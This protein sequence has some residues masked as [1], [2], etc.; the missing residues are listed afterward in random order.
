M[1]TEKEIVSYLYEFGNTKESDII[2]YG[3]K[4]FNYSSEK[5]KKVI[6]RMAIKGKIHYV[7][8]SKLEP[9]EVYI[10][11]KEPLPPEI[12]KIL[13]EAFIQMNAAEEDAQKILDEATALAE[14]RI[15][16]KHSRT[17]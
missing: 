8:H 9:P 7:I 12:A 13:L 15:K 5:M 14:K 10:S 2:N 3:V 11:L 17:F 16:E 1:D 4:K 6:K